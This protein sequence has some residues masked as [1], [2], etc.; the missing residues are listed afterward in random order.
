MLGKLF[1][2]AAHL[3]F[4]HRR[5][6]R[7]KP[8][9]ARLKRASSSQRIGLI[10]HATPMHGLA[11]QAVA[12]VVVHGCQ[13]GVDGDFVKVGTAQAR[14]LRVHIRV[15]APCQQRVVREVNAGNHVSSAKG[16]L[17]G[18]G[19]KVVGIAV[20]HHAPHRNDRY[21]FFRNQLGGVEHVKAELLAL[22]LGE[23]LQAQLPLREVA[24]LNGLPQI[25]PVKVGVGS[26]DFDGLVPHQR[27][28]AE[29]GLPVK[30][31]K[32]RFIRAVDEP[33]CVHAKAMHHAVAARDAPV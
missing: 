23:D 22:G 29:F 15:D 24:R 11:M 32:Y 27:M 10:R 30:L 31:A 2:V 3:V 19:E 20:E 28:G 6:K 14:D 12:L 13:G 4:V 1:G 5:G 21:Q 7:H 8:G 9:G 25:T 16:H 17:F 26:R 33:E 18:L